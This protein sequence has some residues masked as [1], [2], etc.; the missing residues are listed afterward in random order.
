MSAET[1]NKIYALH[2]KLAATLAAIHETK[3][4]TQLVRARALRRM[5]RE[6]GA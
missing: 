2:I 3:N 6:Y 1:L 4:Y 5:L